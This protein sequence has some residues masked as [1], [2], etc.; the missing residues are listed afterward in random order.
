MV[1]AV[2]HREITE[3]VRGTLGC[4]CPDRVFEKIEV[5]DIAAGDFP[6]RITRVV[7]GDTLVVYIVRPDD[8]RQLAG[9]IDSLAV[10]GRKDRDTQGYN[11]YRLVVADDGAGGGHEAAVAR[12]TEVAGSDDKMHIHFVPPD[13]VAFSG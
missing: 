6:G 8:S 13:S 9:Y 3:L 2:S 1:T 7:V 12:F 11:R 4:T 5:G 10:L